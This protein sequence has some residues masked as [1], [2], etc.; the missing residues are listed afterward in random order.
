MVTSGAL[1]VII[2]L[3]ACKKNLNGTS[4]PTF[5]YITRLL[6]IYL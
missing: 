3:S 6:Y 2:D 1:V 5:T 4:V